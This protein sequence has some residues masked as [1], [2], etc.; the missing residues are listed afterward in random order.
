LSP[1]RKNKSKQ[2]TPRNSRQ[3]QLHKKKSRNNVHELLK[4]NNK[5]HIKNNIN[6]LLSSAFYMGFDPPG[7]EKQPRLQ[8]WEDTLLPSKVIDV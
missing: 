8:S 6:K 1:A 4:K 2:N 3:K 7:Q 5:T